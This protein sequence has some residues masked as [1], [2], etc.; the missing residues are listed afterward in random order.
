MFV[1]DPFTTLDGI[2]V[3]FKEQLPKAKV[4]LDIIDMINR[5]AEGIS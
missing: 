5:N 4:I 3:V 2:T 1:Q